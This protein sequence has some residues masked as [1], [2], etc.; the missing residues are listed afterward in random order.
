MP[1]YGASLTSF[2]V[3]AEL[4]RSASEAQHTFAKGLVSGLSE[5]QAPGLSLKPADGLLVAPGFRF[6]FWN[7]LDVRGDLLGSTSAA[8]FRTI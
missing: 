1:T 4:L 6:E 3:T 8:R 7:M 2:A 5:I